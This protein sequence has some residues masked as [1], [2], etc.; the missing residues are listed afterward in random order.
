MGSS[1]NERLTDLKSHG[2]KYG[3]DVSG[4]KVKDLRDQQA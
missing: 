3:Q 1:H 2:I 4:E